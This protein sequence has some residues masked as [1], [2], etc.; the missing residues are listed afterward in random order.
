MAESN[1]PRVNK[2]L[3]EAR[4]GTS[5]DN[6]D[7]LTHMLDGGKDRTLQRRRLL[8][9]V[10]AEG[11]L[12]QNRDDIFLD[13]VGQYRKALARA[14]R[15][16]EMQAE[17][18]LE[19]DEVGWQTL[20][21]CAAFDD[22]TTLHELMFVPNIKA[23]CSESQQTHW[24]PLCKDWR[25]VGCYAQT[26]VGHGSNVRALETTATYLPAP[27]DAFEGR[28]RLSPWRAA[29]WWR[30]RWHACSPSLSHPVG[31]RSDAT[32]ARAGDATTARAAGRATDRTRANDDNSSIVV[33]FPSGNKK[34]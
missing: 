33:S 28:R 7:A 30:W 6:I 14:R 5:I 4:N 15:L 31:S 29:C 9:A 26:E 18:G 2:D 22:P 34:V 21:L 27:I 16:K 20:K 32:A 8:A 13:R 12:F 23:L 25:V 19:E 17:L 11:D 3:E 24:L 10:E 1:D